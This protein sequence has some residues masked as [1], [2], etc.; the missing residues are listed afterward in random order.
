MIKPFKF[1][2]ENKFNIEY[3]PLYH[4]NV[5]ENIALGIINYC[6]R[7]DRVPIGWKHHFYESGSED[8]RGVNKCIEIT[9][10]I[11][12]DYFESR[13]VRIRY[14]VHTINRPGNSD[15]TETT[16]HTFHLAEDVFNEAITRYETI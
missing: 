14:D 6:Y 16:N 1:F 5:Y 12:H 9:D 2:N 7:T 15:M 13:H 8:R 4:L 11:S 3:D 10:L